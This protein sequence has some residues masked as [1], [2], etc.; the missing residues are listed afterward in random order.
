[1]TRPAMFTHD[2]ATGHYLPANKNAVAVAAILSKMR[3]TL[4]DLL[5]VRALGYL[6][7]LQNGREIG[8]V[9]IQA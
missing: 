5:V 7:V 3:L 6:L 2:P 9:D 4:P 1:M 8:R